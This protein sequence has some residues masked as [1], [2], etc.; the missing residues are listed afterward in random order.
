[1]HEAVVC[2]PTPSQVGMRSPHP[3][4][5]RVVHEKI[6]EARANHAPLWGAASSLHQYAI[7]FHGR[8]QPSFDVE[9][10]PF[11][12]HMLSHR[13]EKEIVRDII[14]GNGDTLLISTVI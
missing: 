4:V 7:L 2:I 12:R 13:L 6:G 10:C 14:E 5:E 3:E 1:M 8:R 9:Q 11:A